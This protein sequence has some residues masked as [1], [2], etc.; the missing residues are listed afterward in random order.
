MYNVEILIMYSICFDEVLF[1][2][3]LILEFVSDLDKHFSQNWFC[4]QI[5]GEF[6]NIHV[7]IKEEN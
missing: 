1:S 3:K 5:V 6:S 2:Q 4:F 7:N